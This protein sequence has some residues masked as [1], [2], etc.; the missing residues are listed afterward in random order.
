V[1]TLIDEEIM[2]S[3]MG[4]CPSETPVECGSGQCLAEGET[5]CA[6]DQWKCENGDCVISPADCIDCGACEPDCP[7]DS[8]VWSC[9]YESSFSS[10]NCADFPPSEGW[11]GMTES[12]VY[13][14]CA[15]Q[16]GADASTIVVTQGETCRYEKC[17]FG[18]CGTCEFTHDGKMFIATGIPSIG[19]T[20]GGGSNYTEGNVCFDY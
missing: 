15:A 20:M 17:V 16:Q 9:R 2:L 12:D 6:G 10:E 3:R 14:V 7:D 11:V 5:C 4:G 18:T 13:N 1:Q 19:C 8:Q